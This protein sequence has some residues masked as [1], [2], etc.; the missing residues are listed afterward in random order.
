MIII[1][2]VIIGAIAI[3]WIGILIDRIGRVKIPLIARTVSWGTDIVPIIS[4]RTIE[5]AIGSTII[6][7]SGT[8]NTAGGRDIIGR[9]PRDFR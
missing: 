3:H 1:V 9:L 8:V 4:G 7:G 5:T 6:I 2:A